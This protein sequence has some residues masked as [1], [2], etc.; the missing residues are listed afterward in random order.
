MRI[1]DWSS[2]VCSSDLAGRAGLDAGRVV[3]EVA[4]AGLDQRGLAVE[5]RV[6]VAEVLGVGGVRQTPG[7]D[8]RLVSHRDLPDRAGGRCSFAAA[9]VPVAND[10]SLDLTRRSIN[11]DQTVRFLFLELGQR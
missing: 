8:V 1:S 7:T 11:F 10:C 2:D 3:A 4:A 6:N 5:R 9:C